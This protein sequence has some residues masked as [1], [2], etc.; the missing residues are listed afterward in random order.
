[1][2]R[3]E[4]DISNQLAELVENEKHTTRI[5]DNSRSRNIAVWLHAVEKYVA[6]EGVE[7]VYGPLISLISLKDEMFAAAVEA[8]GGNQLWQIVVDN[9]DTAAKLMKMLIR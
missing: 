6:E 2:W 1:M 8:V 9:D 7:G 3:K 5:L 4:N